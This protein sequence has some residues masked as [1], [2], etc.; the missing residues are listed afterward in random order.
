MAAK[1]PPPLPTLHTPHTSSHTHTQ[2]VGNG[3]SQAGNPML[4]VLPVD[5]A[6]AKG[7]R[8]PSPVSIVQCPEPCLSRRHRM[9]CQ[10]RNCSDLGNPCHCPSS[11]SCHHS[12]VFLLG[13]ID[14]CCGQRSFP[15]ICH[16]LRCQWPCALTTGVKSYDIQKVQNDTQ[17]L[18]YSFL[19]FFF[20]LRLG[21]N[22]LINS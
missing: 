10:T 15:R 16:S 6:H 22:F 9:T 14:Y 8:A 11:S 1:H 4:N 5:D 12:V 21:V 2:S 7:K 19:S 17:Y 18:C 13:N 3:F 20:I